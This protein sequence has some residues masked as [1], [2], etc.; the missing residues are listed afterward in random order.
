VGGFVM[1][2]LGRVP[3]PADHF[4]WEDLRFEIMDMDRNRI[5]K[6]LVAR[7]TGTQIPKS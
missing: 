5:D 6:V 4:D 7:R 2:Q 1:M 3:K